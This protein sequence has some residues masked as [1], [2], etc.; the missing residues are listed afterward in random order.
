LPSTPH[1]SFVWRPEGRIQGMNHVRGKTPERPKRVSVGSRLRNQS[2]ENHRHRA[3]AGQGVGHGLRDN[4]DLD[5]IGRT[6]PGP[7]RAGLKPPGEMRLPRTRVHVDASA[8]LGALAL[9]ELFDQPLQHAIRTT[10]CSRDIGS[11]VTG[12]TAFVAS[13]W[14]IALSRTRNFRRGTRTGRA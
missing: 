7:S 10:R 1:P 11:R 4:S 3:L 12:L 13:H 8:A 6:R 5:L 14:K 9:D 2:A